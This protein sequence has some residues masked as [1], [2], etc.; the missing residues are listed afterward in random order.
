MI[1]ETVK[2][3]ISEQLEI[4]I[5]SETRISGG[6]INQAAKLFTNRGDLF[7]KWNPNAPSD[8]FEKEAQG[9]E[10]LRSAESEV[11]VPE[12][13]AHSPQKDNEPGFLAMKYISPSSGSGDDAFRF[14]A[15]LAKLHQTTGDQF[16]LDHDNYIGRLHQTNDNYSNWAKFFAEMRISPQ[17]KMAVDTGKLPQSI[18]QNSERLFSRLEEFFP[19]TSPS[20]LHGDLWGGNYFFDSSGTAVLI[21]PA[22]YFGHPEMDLA[23]SRMFG[24]FS[25]TF[26]QGYE[27][28]TPLAPGFEQRIAVYNLYPLLVHVNLFGS[29]YASQARRFLEKY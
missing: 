29:G 21:D 4:T 24:G 8:M 28:V 13:L 2:H 19:E 16:G 7:L 6:D 5:L 17:L 22:V 20:L 12:V 15:E 23:F 11:R 27:S 10:L 14:G 25:E 26:Y 1:P 9:L 3:Y 18:L